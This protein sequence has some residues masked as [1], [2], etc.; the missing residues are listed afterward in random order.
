M[1]E[2]DIDDIEFDFFDEPTDEEVT[3][4][5][6]AVRPQRQQDRGPRGPR[7]P[8][9]RPP[10]GLTP[11]LRLVGLIAF[12]ILIVVL[13]V[14][15]VQSCQSDKKTQAYKNYMADVRTIAQSSAQS[16]R[17][18]NDYLTTPGIK[19]DDLIGKLNGLAQQEQ[20]NVDRA[21]SLDPPGHLRDAHQHV[22]EALQFRVNGLRGLSDALRST[23]SSKDPEKAGALLAQQAQR[24]VTSD[25]VWDDLFKAPAAEI[26]D[27]QGIHGVAPPDSGFV[28]NPD[29]ASSRT[30]AIF[31]QRIH[32]AATGGTTPGLH[33]T[34]LV[35]VKALPSGTTLSTSTDTPVI[36]SPSLAFQATVRN[37]GD[38][39]EVQVPV[40]LTIQKQGGPIVKRETIDVINPGEEKTVTFREI[41][42]TGVFG[43]RTNLIVRVGLVPGEK[44]ASNNSATYPVIFSLSP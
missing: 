22:V 12:A 36:A 18:L 1:S 25:V 41:D 3:Q 29:L 28:Q 4:R 43:V 38:N 15:W 23:A 17:Q 10:A 9:M 8:P 30:F 40:T 21:T 11:L 27:Q 42:T 34:G 6:R 26:L 31:F 5:R 39:Q 33:G 24:L 2:R 44:N 19:L 32:G 35:S 37:T 20:Q 14:F 13:L 7:R 16:G